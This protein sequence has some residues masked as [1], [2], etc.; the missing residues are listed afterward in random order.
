MDLGGQTT[1]VTSSPACR[2][3]VGMHPAFAIPAAIAFVAFCFW[4]V[5]RSGDRPTPKPPVELKM[6]PDLED[7]VARFQRLAEE[8]RKRGEL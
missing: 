5:C 1:W 2:Y 7:T 8:T 4:C 6:R 3:P